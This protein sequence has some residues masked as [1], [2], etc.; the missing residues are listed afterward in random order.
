MNEQY[1]TFTKK[2]GLINSRA[3]ETVFSDDSSYFLL[4]SLE[5]VNEDKELIRKADMFV[6]RTIKPY[7]KID[8]VDTARMLQGERSFVRCITSVSTVF[9]RESITEA[10]SSITV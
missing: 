1:D 7:T 6:K 5:V 10:I 3:N 8:R 2:Y 4:S 9:A